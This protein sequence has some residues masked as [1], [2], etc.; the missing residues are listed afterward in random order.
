MYL[1]YIDGFAYDRH[2][3][4]DCI[5]RSNVYL[6]LSFPFIVHNSDLIYYVNDQVRICC[7]DLFSFHL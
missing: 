2:I 5:S 7:I 3:I 6:S 4:D 1:A